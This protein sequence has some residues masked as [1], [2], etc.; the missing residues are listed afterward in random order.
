M[1]TTYAD[2][3]NEFNDMVGRACA[4]VEDTLT[5]KDIADELRKIADQVEK[6]E[7]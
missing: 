3:M 7:F 2:A 5:R 6:G 1:D 4:L